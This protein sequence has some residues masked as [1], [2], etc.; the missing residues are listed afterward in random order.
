M[1]VY[2]LRVDKKP[3]TNSHRKD[4]RYL[5]NIDYDAKCAM[6]CSLPSATIF[7]NKKM[8]RRAANILDKE[9]E[10][11]TII[12]IFMDRTFEMPNIER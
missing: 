5:G 9:K 12:P 11:I 2:V 6:F 7:T 3:W 10:D 1:I 8:A 4:K